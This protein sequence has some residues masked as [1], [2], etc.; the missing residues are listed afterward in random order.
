[1]F[2]AATALTAG[3]VAVS[4][5]APAGAEPACIK[6][7]WPGGGTLSMDVANGTHAVIGTSNDYVV[8]T[9]FYTPAN[10]PGTSQVSYGTG[11]GG[12]RN[13][14]KLD[15]TINWTSGPGNG[16]SWHFTGDIDAQGLARGNVATPDGA[17]GWSSTQQF[18][19]IEK[20][21]PPPPPPP[22][23]P[24]PC[25][26]GS[27][28]PEV[29][30]PE[31]CAPPTDAVRMTIG[32]GALQRTVTVTNNGPLGGTCAY[33]AKATSGVFAPGLNRQIN[34]GPNASTSIDV[35][36]PPLG[37]TYHVTLKCTGEYDG[38]QVQFGQAEQDVSSF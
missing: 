13:G 19:C 16:K 7:L 3:F 29:I 36:A 11:S 18:S 10:A 25:P 9:P 30:E 1:M 22:P 21:A 28:K 14:T 32:G 31:K 20:A 33:D 27:V 17:A 2:V 15:F 6:Y 5:A 38:K 4:T 8:G 26:P 23:P 37:S 35:P 12:I 24:K 34:V